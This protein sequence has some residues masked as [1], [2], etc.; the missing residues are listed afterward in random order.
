M[1]CV[2]TQ[3]FFELVRVYI[4]WDGQDFID[5]VRVYR[6][7]TIVYILRCSKGAFLFHSG[8][9]SNLKKKKIGGAMQDFIELVRVY[10]PREISHRMILQ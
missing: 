9:D 10:I 4:C 2:H 5:L 7:Y 8:L 1:P 3:D 6:A